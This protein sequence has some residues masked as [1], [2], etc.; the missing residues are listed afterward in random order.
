MNILLM[1]LRDWAYRHFRRR[2]VLATLALGLVA[3]VS[4]ISFALWLYDL[5]VWDATDLWPILVLPGH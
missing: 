4:A 1:V 2:P 5:T 3:A